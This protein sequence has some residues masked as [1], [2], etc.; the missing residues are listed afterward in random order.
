[1][2]FNEYQLQ[3]HGFADYTIP[4]AEVKGDDVVRKLDYTY[5]AMG[6]AEESGEVL[7]K[8]AKAVRDEGGYISPKRKEEIVKELGD[9]AWFVSELCTLMNVSFEEV[10]TK[11]IEKLTSR[12]ERG[13]IKGSGD[14]R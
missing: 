10:C 7:G 9:V 1:M 11:N 14:N 6:L 4:F 3:A 5:P 2:T 8:F 12:K 13:V